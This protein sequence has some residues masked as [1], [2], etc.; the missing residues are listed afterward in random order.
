MIRLDANISARGQKQSR[1]RTHAQME[2]SSSHKSSS[3]D[4]GEARRGIYKG[5]TGGAGVDT[6]LRY[7]IKVRQSRT[8]CREHNHRFSKSLSCLPISP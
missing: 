2:G 1:S 8:C 4:V 5:G 7:G 3:T 6:N